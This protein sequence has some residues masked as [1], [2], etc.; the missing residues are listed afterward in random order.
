MSVVDDVA[1]DGDDRQRTA[2]DTRRREVIVNRFIM[3]D[4]SMEGG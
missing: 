2:A 3:I 1:D 4:M